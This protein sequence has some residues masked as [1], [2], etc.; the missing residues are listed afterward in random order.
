MDATTT[1]GRRRAELLTFLFLAFVLIPVL[2][3]GVVGAYGFAI[4]MVQM[5]AGPPGM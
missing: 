4:W 5:V 1:T 2:S 3:V